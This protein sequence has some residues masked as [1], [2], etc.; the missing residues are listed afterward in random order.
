MLLLINFGS[1]NKSFKTVHFYSSAHTGQQWYKA[2]ITF[3]TDQFLQFLT[4]TILIKYHLSVQ[5]MLTV[6]QYSVC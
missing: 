6:Y 2:A 3:M 5:Y 1:I 4:S